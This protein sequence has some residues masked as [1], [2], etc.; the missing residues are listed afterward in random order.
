MNMPLN[1][2]PLGRKTE[3]LDTYTPALLCP[4]P[5]WDARE[6]LDVEMAQLPFNG[7]D[8]WTAYELS[9]LDQRGKPMVA[10]AEIRVPCHTRNLVESKSFKLYLNS[11]ANSKFDDKRAVAAAM[12]QDLSECAGGAVDVHVFTLEEKTREPWMDMV[13][14]RV[15]DIDLDVSDYAYDPDLLMTEQGPQR[16]ETLYSHLLRSRCPVTGQPDWATVIVRYSG[17]P[18]SHASFLRYIISLRNHQGFHEQV[19]ERIYLDLMSR[20]DP[21]HLTV[22]GRFTRR[23]G[24]DINPFRSNFEDLPVAHRVVRQ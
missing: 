3:Y 16:N 9:W 22:Y 15:D 24:L 1:E 2:T 18:I 11:F 19:I 17:V 13:G 6:E 20:C 12:E 10:M 7:V 8:V 21:S 5:R 23:G 14:T 4:V